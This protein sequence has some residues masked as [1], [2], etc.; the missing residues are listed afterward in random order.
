[1]K[2]AAL[3]IAV[4]ALLPAAASA[5]APYEPNDSAET[6]K[7]LAAGT[8]YAAALETSNDKD[9][10]VFYVAEPQTQVAVDVTNTTPKQN[11]AEFVLGGLYDQK[12]ES[13]LAALDDGV[14]GLA[15][16]ES[17]RM[18]YT[19]GPGRY[20]V[21]F[22]EGMFP[23]PGVKSYQFTVTGN[24]VDQA[25]LQAKCNGAKRSERAAR[26]SLTRARRSLTR[27]RRRGRPRTVSRA[28]RRV[29]AAQRRLRA[30]SRTVR[31]YCAG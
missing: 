16:G 5:Q 13:R 30:A 19:F 31:V 15:E 27:A 7:P 18:A 25:G 29:R 22:E 11:G 26:R 20:Y 17:G 1:M 14:F 24:I 10:F 21:R 12:L 9:V 23:K 28:K 2:T 4:L 6:A 3:A 8:A